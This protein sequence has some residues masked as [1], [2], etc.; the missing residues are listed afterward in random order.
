MVK[1]CVN[2][3]RAHASFVLVNPNAYFSSALFISWHSF[4]PGE[5]GRADEARADGRL[6]PDLPA[7]EEPRLAHVQGVHHAA[8]RRA[9]EG[10]VG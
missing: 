10:R 7:L 3:N 5:D 2:S 4:F 6:V 1:G 9:Q 8:H